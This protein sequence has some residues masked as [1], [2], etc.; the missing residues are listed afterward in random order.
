[1]SHNGIPTVGL[2]YAE[3]KTIGEESKMTII[4]QKKIE[5]ILNVV[6]DKVELT[7]RDD[8]A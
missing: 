8:I 6:T 7:E 2:T 1:M 5:I 3:R 4:K